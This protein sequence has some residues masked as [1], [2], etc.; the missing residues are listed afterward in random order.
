MEIEH[1]Q[2][3]VELMKKRKQTKGQHLI[4]KYNGNMHPSGNS[5]CHKLALGLISK[6]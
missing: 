6:N 2:L 4:S 1:M 3:A 5:H